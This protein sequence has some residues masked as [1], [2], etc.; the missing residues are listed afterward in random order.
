MKY[1]RDRSNSPLSVVSLQ[2]GHRKIDTTDVHYDR[3]AIAV[4][5]RKNRLFVELK[6]I[7]KTIRDKNFK[8][9]LHK[10]KSS[11]S[12]IGSIR[13][14]NIPNHDDVIWGCGDSFKPD[15]PN[16]NMYIREGEKCSEINKCLSCS[17]VRVF[18]DSLTFLF[19]RDRLLRSRFN[20]DHE[21]TPA[22]VIEELEVIQYIFNEW[23]DEKA[24]KRAARISSR[25]DLEIPLNL[26]A[27]KVGLED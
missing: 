12:K 1:T 17:K 16:A 24:I 20:P 19:H 2:Q 22:E 14:F 11:D 23:G 25:N 27:L 6:H 5:E 26:S 8:G 9:M 21:S 13:L 7:T 10:S 3:S 15:F 4:N 18:E